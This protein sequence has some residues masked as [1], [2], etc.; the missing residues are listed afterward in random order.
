MEENMLAPEDFF[1]L[2]LF[3][4]SELFEGL[5]FVWQ[6]LPLI[7]D[8]L[9]RV[10]G[11]TVQPG[12]HGRIEE[13]AA[14]VNRDAI[15]IGEGTTVESG[16]YMAGPAIIGKECEI[17]QGAYIR[18]NV[19][20]G[21]SCVVGHA[22]ELKNTVMFNGSH[23]PHFA[24]VGDSVLGNRVNLGAGTKLSNLSLLSEKDPKT[25]KR[26]TLQIEIEGKVYDTGLSKFGCILGDEAQTG[27]NVV[28][29]PGCLIGK[30]TLVYSN[31]SLHKGYYPPNSIVKL[32]QTLDVVERW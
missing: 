4:H 5:E 15:F 14:L 19:V 21:D 20:I 13:G 24:Y 22:S 12:I 18:G 2:S 29:N 23:A 8:Y 28:T 26:P 11:H 31:I 7:E 10:I 25:G 3:E 6:V 27:C 16:A 30:R 9:E 17:R 1:D 32:R